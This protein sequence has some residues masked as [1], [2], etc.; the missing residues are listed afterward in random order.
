M[1]TYQYICLYFFLL[2]F[3][4]AKSQQKDTSLYLNKR[5]SFYQTGFQFGMPFQNEQLPEG[6]YIPIMLQANLDFWIRRKNRTI[7]AKHKFF[8]YLEP[9]FNPIKIK[10][11]S[12]SFEVGSNIGFKYAY[13]F[14][15]INSIRVNIGSGPQYQAF[16]SLQQSGGFIFSDNF[17]IGYQHN[18][19][20][21]PLYVN[22]GYRFRHISNLD[23]QLPNKGID[24]HFLVLGFGW[25]KV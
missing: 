6:K 3:C 19:A 10:N 9:Y 16:E 24:T 4:T 22:I 1:N 14:N 20:T 17:G 7:N 13:C 25:R 18:F 12:P 5:I 21:H 2:I 23:L 15:D 11:N 8:V